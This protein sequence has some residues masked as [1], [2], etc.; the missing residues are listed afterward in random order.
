MTGEKPVRSNII[1]FR[2]WLLTQRRAEMVLMWVIVLRPTV[3]VFKHHPGQ[4]SLAIL[5][6]VA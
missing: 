6:R 3:F 2:N 4:L 1:R 5:P